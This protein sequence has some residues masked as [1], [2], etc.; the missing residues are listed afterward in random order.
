MK[1]LI[2]LV[3]FFF[4]SNPLFAQ[5]Q[6][7]ETEIIDHSNIEPLILGHKKVIKKFS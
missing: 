2:L 5:D 4:L 7:N 6:E 1:I 3:S